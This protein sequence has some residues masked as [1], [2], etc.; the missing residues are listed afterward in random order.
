M[1]S[2]IQTDKK[3]KNMYMLVYVAYVYSFARSIKRLFEHDK[4]RLVLFIGLKESTLFQFPK[5][6]VCQRQLSNSILQSVPKR[7]TRHQS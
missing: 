7:Y 5:R 2:K 3:F 4:Q 6:N 1:K